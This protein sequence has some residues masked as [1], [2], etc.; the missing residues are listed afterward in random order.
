MLAHRRPDENLYD[1]G[2]LF[3][4]FSE[5]DATLNEKPLALTEYKMLYLFRKNPEPVS[6]PAAVFGAVAARGREI[7]G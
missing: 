6:D 2:R 1:D 5:Q 4:G 3:L 7:C